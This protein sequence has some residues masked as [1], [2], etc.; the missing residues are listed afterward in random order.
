MEEYSSF[1]DSTMEEG[2]GEEGKMSPFKS[3][4]LSSMI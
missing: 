1:P 2:K 3:L 4:L